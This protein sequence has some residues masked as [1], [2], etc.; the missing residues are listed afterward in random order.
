[1]WRVAC[2]GWPNSWDLVLLELS[3]FSLVCLLGL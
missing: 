1:V 2:V 3:L